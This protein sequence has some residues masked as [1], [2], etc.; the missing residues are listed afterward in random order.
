MIS[1][2]QYIDPELHRQIIWTAKHSMKSHVEC[3]FWWFTIVLETIVLNILVGK[4]LYW[5]CRGGTGGDNRGSRV[6]KWILWATQRFSRNDVWKFRYLIYKQFL[7]TNT[8]IYLQLQGMVGKWILWATKFLDMTLKYLRT[9]IHFQNAVE[10]GKI[11]F[12]FFR[13]YICFVVFFGKAR[14]QGTG[15]RTFRSVGN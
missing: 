13:K 15:D 14:E 9:T 6:S 1:K 7:L 3:I 12:I 5:S 11:V 8:N 10:N 4:P 2:E